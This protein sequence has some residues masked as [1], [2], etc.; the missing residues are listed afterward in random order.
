MKILHRAWSSFKGKVKLFPF[1]LW[2]KQRS[3]SPRAEENFFDLKSDEVKHFDLEWCSTSQGVEPTNSMYQLSPV[4]DANNC[5]TVL[6]WTFQI[7]AYKLSFV[8]LE[9]G[10]RN[11]S[12]PK[13]VDQWGRAGGGGWWAKAE[14]SRWGVFSKRIRVAAWIM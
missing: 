2:R 9:F 1:F 12:C 4:G 11:F 10:L 6:M 8:N 14:W 3:R 13:G 5:A 7:L